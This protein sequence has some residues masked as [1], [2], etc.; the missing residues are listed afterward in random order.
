MKLVLASLLMAGLSWA[1]SP[2]EF[3]TEVITK[4]VTATVDSQNVIDWKKGDQNSYDLDMGGFIKGS[5]IQTVRDITGEGMWVDQDMDLGF[6][7]KQQA[8]QLIDPATGEIKKFIVN[9]KEEKIPE[10]GEQEIVDV[11]ESKIT[12]PAGTFD[13]IAAKIKDKKSGDITEAW[14]NPEKVS[15][16]GMLKIIQPSQFGKVT[17]ALKS[18]KKN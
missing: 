12:V 15:I 17:I 7:G 8:S 3:T 5:M 1:A 13:C 18:F 6:A 16:G 2:V 10:Q 11:T 14:I 4:V 9:G